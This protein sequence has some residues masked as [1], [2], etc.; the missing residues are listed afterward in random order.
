[1]LRFL[2][3][4]LF[5]F[6]EILE[7]L[8]SDF[9]YLL[10]VYGIY[11]ALSGSEGNVTVKHRVLSLFHGHTDDHNGKIVIIVKHGK[12]LVKVAAL[13]QAVGGVCIQHPYTEY[14]F[15]DKSQCFCYEYS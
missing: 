1:M 2:S 11:P 6:P 14:E 4:S 15:D 7:S 8:N 5:D 12:T 10:H 13:H 3:D 9:G